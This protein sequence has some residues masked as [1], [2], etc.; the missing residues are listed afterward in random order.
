M[1]RKKPSR[2]LYTETT[3]SYKRK[4]MPGARQSEPGDCQ[5]TSRARECLNTVR[6]VQTSTCTAPWTLGSGLCPQD[7]PGAPRPH[8]WFHHP[9]VK[10]WEGLN[11]W[12][13]WVRKSQTSSMHGLPWNGVHFPHPESSTQK[14][15][16]EFFPLNAPIST[17]LK[18]IYASSSV[19][20][21]L[22]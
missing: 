5:R 1:Q 7:S 16:K 9:L 21:F 22:Y 14:P 4:K 19:V 2:P 10:S 13:S 11:W 6:A 17:Y 12:I 3:Q 20:Q 8:S 18:Q 15:S